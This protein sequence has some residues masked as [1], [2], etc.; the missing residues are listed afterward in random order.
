MSRT[1]VCPYARTNAADQ[2]G[3]ANAPSPS[4]GLTSRNPYGCSLQMQVP[5]VPSGNLNQPQLR[6]TSTSPPAPEESGECN[7]FRALA[8]VALDPTQ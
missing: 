2:N 5:G 1:C 8:L 3:R 7:L 4:A 6:G